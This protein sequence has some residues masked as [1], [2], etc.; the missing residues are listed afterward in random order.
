M[1]N[2]VRSLAL[3]RIAFG[4]AMLLKPEAAVRGWI[5]P[6]SAAMGGTQTITQAFAARDVALGACSLA[7]LRSGRAAR[8]WVIAGALCDCTAQRAP[9]TGEDLPLSGRITV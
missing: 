8:D 7:P 5:G 2:L 6:R 3:G 9:L 4:G 1:R